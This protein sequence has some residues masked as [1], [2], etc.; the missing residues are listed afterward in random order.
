MKIN[1][2]INLITILSI[3]LF[4][5]CQKQDI[6]EEH[7]TKQSINYRNGRLV[8]ETHEEFKTLIDKVKSNPSINSDIFFINEIGNDYQKFNEE[9]NITKQN[10][11]KQQTVPSKKE[12]VE[13]LVDD[14]DF[15]KLLNS[16]N[17]IEVEGT[18][19]KITEYGTFICS[20]H[21]YDYLNAIIEKYENN[22]NVQESVIEGYLYKIEDGILRY[23]TFGE[24][25]K[26]TIE[27]NAYMEDDSNPASDRVSRIEE[28]I[29]TKVIKDRHTIVGGFIQD[30]FG[31]SASYEREFSSSRRVKV[32]FSSPNFVLFSYINA[33]VK[34]QKK[35]WI[36]W[37]E[38]NCEQLVLGWDGI[39]YSFKSPFSKPTPIVTDPLSNNPSWHAKI[40][41][42]AS[43]KEYFAL[44]LPEF[45]FV[46]IEDKFVLNYDFDL[47]IREKDLSKAYKAAFNW[48]KRKANAGQETQ[49][50]AIPN[51]TELLVG[52]EEFI[53]R[54]QS[55]ISKTFDYT[56][57]VI[58]FKFNPN[59]TVGISN[60]DV[61]PLSFS[62]KYASIYGK[63]YND[64]RW[65]G[66]RIEKH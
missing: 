3:I 63:A 57:G 29:E 1:F 13:E 6:L 20:I 65:L 26:N 25:E 33:K 17:E 51:Q 31:F 24:T 44:D 37:S 15:S 2:V 59:T 34:F 11:L 40:K 52:P 27:Y 18:I 60:F 54:N 22:E 12:E 36:G 64:G 49:F 58:T 9:K 30:T 8:F 28:E 53:E 7:S 23:D 62:M 46:V 43:N 61:K 38:T 66:L 39:N 48:L 41:V 19:Y 21:K 55:E 16:Q 4:S 47:R 45:N 42:P 10:L 50:A 56:I 14:K 35:N 32:K 5:S